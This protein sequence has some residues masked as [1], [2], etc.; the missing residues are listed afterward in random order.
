MIQRKFNCL[1]KKNRKIR[2][3]LSRRIWRIRKLSHRTK[4]QKLS[5]FRGGR[6]RAEKGQIKIWI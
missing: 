3:R 5:M 6:E 4:A 1:R 2:S